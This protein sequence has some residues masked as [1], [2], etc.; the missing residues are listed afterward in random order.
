MRVNRGRHV[1]INDHIDRQ[2]ISFLQQDGRIPNTTLAK[3]IGIS[4][5]TV[6][7][8]L[9]RLINDRIIQIVAV[10]DPFK[11]GFAIAGNLKI[12]VEAKK[13]PIVARELKNLKELWYIALTTGSMDI[14]AEF[15]R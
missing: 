8:R 7:S 14:D 15:N 9:N 13:M 2:L 3:K 12:H 10:S 11:L 6:R 5:A 1:K 4:E